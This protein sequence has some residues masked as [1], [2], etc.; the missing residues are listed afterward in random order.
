MQFIIVISMIFAIF[1]AVFAL[2]NSAVATINFLW[3]KLSLSQAV[4]ILGSALFG[5]LIM[6]PFDIIKR[7][8]NSMK[9]SELNNQIKKLKEEL[10]TIKKDNAPHLTDDI[11][12][13]EEKL[14]GNKESVQK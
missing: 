14:D 1:I 3:Y 12:E 4:V 8:K 11:K 9:T 10:E 6:I 7:I 5:I 2:Q 13:L